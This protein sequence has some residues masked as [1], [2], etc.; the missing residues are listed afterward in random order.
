VRYVPAA[1]LV[2]LGVAACGPDA[3]RMGALGNGQIEA[4]QS[5]A[6]LLVQRRAGEGQSGVAHVEA[7]FVQFPS[8][9]P[10]ILPDLLHLPMS[11]SPTSTGCTLPNEAAVEDA[12]GR[13][14]ARSVDVGPIDV[15]AG[16]RVVRM[17]PWRYLDQY[18]V[19]YVM[20]GVI[21]AS[22]DS[23]PT[24]PWRFHALGNPESHVG[25]FFVDDRTAPEAITDLTLNNQAIAPDGTVVL[26]RRGFALRWT[27]GA[28]S[29][30]VVATF[31]GTGSDGPATVACTASDA[32]GQLEVTPAWAERIAEL[33][34]SGATVTVHRIR[35]ERI[36]VPLV[37]HGQL[38]FDLSTRVRAATE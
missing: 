16:E 34:R 20:S 29:D 21:Y 35:I 19:D 25:E 26:P 2:V 27:R 22:D 18:H 4:P 11:P 24:N 33:S 12:D 30:T 13:V 1:L 17:E 6:V 36:N 32:S 28:P 14:E 7:R 10:D 31:E 23:L 5:V 9:A 38:V 8:S 3:S 37:D 15:Q